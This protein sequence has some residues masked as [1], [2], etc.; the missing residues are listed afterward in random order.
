MNNTVASH[1]ESRATARGRNSGLLGFLF[2]V[3][4]RQELPGVAVSRL[5]VTLGVAEPTV[6]ALLARMRKAGDIATTRRGRGVDYRLAGRF[7]AGFRR[8]RDHDRRADVP[9]DGTFH[10]LLYHVPESQRPFRDA[11]RRAAMFTGYGL[12]QQGVL[13]SLGDNRERLADVLEDCPPEARIQFARLTLEPADAVRAAAVAWDLAGM[14]EIYRGH[15]AHLGAALRE[16]DPP[17]ATGDTLVRFAELSMVPMVDTLADPGLPAALL[18]DD[19]PL[20]ELWRIIG[21]IHALYGPPA[22]AYVQRVIAGVT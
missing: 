13:I 14:A 3:A 19:W 10:A 20:P 21:E 2:G 4:G 9:W 11:L 16:T 15:I 7:A 22:G 1:V 18:P 5:M 12:L 6:R 17:P 8:I